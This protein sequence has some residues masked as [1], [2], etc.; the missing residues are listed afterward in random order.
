MARQSF[1][2]RMPHAEFISTYAPEY[3]KEEPAKACKFV[4]RDNQIPPS[5]FKIG[6]SMILLKS[7]AMSVMEVERSRKVL[8]YV[9]Y[10]Y[11]RKCI[12]RHTDS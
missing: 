6:S 7:E 12:Y 8:T 10:P 4:M 1:P 2:M 3:G 11:I 5:R 9:R